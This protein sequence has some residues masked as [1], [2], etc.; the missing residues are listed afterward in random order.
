[1][2]AAVFGYYTIFSPAPAALLLHLF[3]EVVQPTIPER[4]FSKSHEVALAGRLPAG[5]TRVKASGT[6]LLVSVSVI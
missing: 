6:A 1:M 5:K 4:S 3:P 2:A